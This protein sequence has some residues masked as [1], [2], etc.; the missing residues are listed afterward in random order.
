VATRQDQERSGEGS[1]GL[2]SS[3]QTFHLTQMHTDHILTFLIVFMGAMTVLLSITVAL[4]FAGRGSSKVGG[5]ILSKALSWQL[6]G[7]AVIGAGTLTFALAE[8]SGHLSG[9]SVETSSALRAVMFIA[10]STTTLHLFLVINKLS[11]A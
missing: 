2:L 6:Y 8:W 1:L 3:G 11:K 9:W 10:T 4:K 7:E 5:S